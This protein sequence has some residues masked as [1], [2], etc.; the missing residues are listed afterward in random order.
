MDIYNTIRNGIIILLHEY[1]FIQLRLVID[2]Y[3]KDIYHGVLYIH[4]L[5][6]YI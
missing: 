5:K 2:I 4:L 1:N 6:H 3:Y